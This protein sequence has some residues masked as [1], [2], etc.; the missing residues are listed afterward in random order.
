MP[1]SP[2]WSSTSAT[3]RLEWRPSRWLIGSLSGLGL[4]AALSLLAADLPPLVAWPGAVVA[5]AYG[6]WLARREAGKPMVELCLRDGVVTVDG[7]PV[8]RFQVDWRGSLA[9]VRWQAAPHRD[10]RQRGGSPRR[11]RLVWW[12]DTLA[13]AERRELRLAAPPETPARTARSMAP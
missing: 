5:M 7:E 2:T 10:T 1:N 8:D 6:M 13:A 12:P 3:C 9:F 11:R 4:S